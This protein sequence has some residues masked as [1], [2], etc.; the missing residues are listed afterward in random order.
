M[1]KKATESTKFSKFIREAK[2][3][4]KKQVYRRVLEKATE[5]QRQ[6]LE[7]SERRSA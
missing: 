3:G 7:G 4:E 1:S 5:R 6:V 2:S